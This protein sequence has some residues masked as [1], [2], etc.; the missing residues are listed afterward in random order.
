MTPS[1]MTLTVHSP[2]RG[3][4]RYA[5]K[6]WAQEYPRRI[7]YSGWE[8]GCFL[9]TSK[10]VLKRKWK[11]P[12]LWFTGCETNHPKN[13]PGIIV[14]AFSRGPYFLCFLLPPQPTPLFLTSKTSFQHLFC[15]NHFFPWKEMAYICTYSVLCNSHQRG[16]ITRHKCVQQKI[17]HLSDSPFRGS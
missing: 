3:K 6:N 17:L 8:L 7:L 13:V 9:T 11:S 10:D 2:L 14:S 12:S 16:F 1:H 5:L 15:S 4:C